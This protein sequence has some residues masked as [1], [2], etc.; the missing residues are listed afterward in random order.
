MT[1]EDSF[2]KRNKDLPKW[3]FSDLWGRAMPES[4][5]RCIVQDRKGAVLKPEP[6]DQSWWRGPVVTLLKHAK[7]FAP[8]YLLVMTAG[9]KWELWLVV[10]W[11]TVTFWLGWSSSSCSLENS[12]FQH[13]LHFSFPHEVL[14]HVA[15]SFSYS[16]QS[17]TLTLV[18]LDSFASCFA[19]T[20][21]HTCIPN[22]TKLP[23]CCCEPDNQLVRL[24]SKFTCKKQTRHSKL[25]ILKLDHGK[26]FYICHQDLA[27]CSS[28]LPSL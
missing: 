18:L 2:L 1:I 25:L 28:F 20:H 6:W 26:I 3:N 9:R 21:T 5:D 15:F 23:K 4:W 24:V 11:V 19:P 14:L 13:A 8:S 17:Q 27:L 16:S 22:V 12:T 7:G 10:V